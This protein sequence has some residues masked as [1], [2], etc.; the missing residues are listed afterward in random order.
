M[1]AG[2]LSVL[3]SMSSDAENF[4]QIVQRVES[5]SGP[6]AALIFILFFAGLYFGIA[7]VAAWAVSSAFGTPYLMTA[8]SIFLLRFALN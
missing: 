7:L 2:N 8:L 5:A 1:E 3:P 6:F 4:W